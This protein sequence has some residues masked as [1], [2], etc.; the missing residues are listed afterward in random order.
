MAPRQ[1]PSLHGRRARPS[2]PLR[3]L[4]EHCGPEDLPPPPPCRARLPG[5]VPDEKPAGLASSGRVAR[6][7]S[8]RRPALCWGCS[9]LPCGH[10]AGGQGSPS[11]AGGTLRCGDHALSSRNWGL[12]TASLRCPPPATCPPHPAWSRPRPT[13][14]APR[15]PQVGGAAPRAPR[16]AGGHCQ[17]PPGQQPVARLQLGRGEW[18]GWR[19]RGLV[20]PA[21][22]GPGTWSWWVGGQRRPWGPPEAASRLL[23]SPGLRPAAAPAGQWAGPAGPGGGVPK[24]WA[25]AGSPCLQP[26]LPGKPAGPPRSPAPPALPCRH[27]S[28]R[29]R[30]CTTAA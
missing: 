12:S 21:P 1:A 29:G 26:P 18:P 11:R 2:E 17:G 8:A 6:G 19:Q 24:S 15:R 4:R 14:P 7:S 3:R 30:P 25:S 23:A 10:R 22:R 9:R 20:G 13:S 16:C 27:S 28:S 5:H